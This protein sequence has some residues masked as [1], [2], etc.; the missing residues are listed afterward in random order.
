MKNCLKDAAVDISSIKEIILVGGSTRLDIV[1]RLLTE[2]FKKP[3][4]N[5]DPEKTVAI[6]AAIQAE[7]LSRGSSNL[8]IDS[9]L[10]RSC[11]V[12]SFV[13]PQARSPNNISSDKLNS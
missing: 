6:G 13:A 11:S 8:L 9:E 12:M 2:N 4:D 10:F 7:G 5:V 1:K 3:L